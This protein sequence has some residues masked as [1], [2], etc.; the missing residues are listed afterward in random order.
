MQKETT[1]FTCVMEKLSIYRFG[2]LWITGNN[3]QPCGVISKTDLAIAYQHGPDP[4][5]A[6]ETVMNSPRAYLQ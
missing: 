2:A 3:Q 4:G 5:V 6:G 1:G